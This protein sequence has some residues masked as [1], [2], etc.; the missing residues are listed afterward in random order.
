MDRKKWKQKIRNAAKSAGTYSPCFDS[1]IDTL[2]G[3][4]EMR[5]IAMEQ[6]DESGGEVIVEHTNTVGATNLAKNPAV[7]AIID[8]NA[9]ALAY[10]RDLGL[11]PAGLKKINEEGLKDGKQSALETALQSFES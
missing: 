5:D 8:C 7:T 4:L 1:M 9:Q 11:T 2:A 6:F 3:I 10:W